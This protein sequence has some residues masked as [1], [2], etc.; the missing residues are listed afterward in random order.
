MSPTWGRSFLTGWLNGT[1][2]EDRQ[3]SPRLQRGFVQD[4]GRPGCQ[5]RTGGPVWAHQ[6]FGKGT[7]DQQ[8]RQIGQV[9]CFRW[10]GTGRPPVQDWENRQRGQAS[11]AVRASQR[12]EASQGSSG[13]YQESRRI[14]DSQC[15]IRLLILPLPGKKEQRLSFQVCGLTLYRFGRRIRRCPDHTAG[16]ARLRQDRHRSGGA[17]AGDLRSSQGAGLSGPCA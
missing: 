13:S 17:G 5:G 2:S 6:V 7:E 3:G 9:D 16:S 11:E 12:V 8:N 14:T 4:Q 10:C 15:Q 1:S